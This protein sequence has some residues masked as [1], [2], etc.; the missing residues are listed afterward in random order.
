MLSHGMDYIDILSYISTFIGDRMQNHDSPIG[1]VGLTLAVSQ[2]SRGGGNEGV[3]RKRYAFP[4]A[5]VA[6]NKFGRL[7]K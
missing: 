1:A 5:A 2:V 4:A 6:A 3:E 7:V